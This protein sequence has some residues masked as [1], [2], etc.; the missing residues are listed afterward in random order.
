MFTL[1]AALTV[2]IVLYWYSR[3]Y[4]LYESAWTYQVPIGK[5]QQPLAKF[6]PYSIIPTLLAVAIGLWWVAIENLFRTVQPFI[7]M[8]RVAASDNGSGLSYQSSYLIWAAVRVVS[9]KHWV[10][11][12]ICTGAF[13]SQI[14]KYAVV[15][16]VVG[17]ELSKSYSHHRNVSF[18]AAS[19]VL[20][21]E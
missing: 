11:A 2:L 1:C 15:T 17:N 12:F 18:M 21:C 3:K 8:T 9:R 20:A 4:G 14:C 19:A 7:S 5:G 13:L 6:A 10:L 16:R